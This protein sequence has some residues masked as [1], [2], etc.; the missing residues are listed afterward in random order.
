[1]VA[2]LHEFFSLSRRLT[3]HGV[4]QLSVYP[5]TMSAY[6]LVGQQ[7]SNASSKLSS[8]DVD[9]NTAELLC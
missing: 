7:L 1:M 4:L 5:C 2:R 3:T 6:F 9:A 8:R